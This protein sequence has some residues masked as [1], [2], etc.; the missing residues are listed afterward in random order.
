ML[1]SSMNNSRPFP[2]KKK[3]LSSMEENYN[4]GNISEH[5]NANEFPQTKTTPFT[6][7]ASKHYFNK[8]NFESIINDN[9]RWDQDQWNVPPGTLALSIALTPFFRTDKRFP[10]YCVEDIVEFMDTKLVFGKEYSHNHFNDDSL[11]L[12]LDRIHEAGSST[13]FSMIASQVYVNFPIAFD[14]IFHLDTTSHVCYGDFKICEQD[15]YEGLNVTYGHSKARRSDKKQI[16]SGMIT[17]SLGIPLHTEVLDGN[18]AD[19]AWFPKAICSFREFFGKMCDESIFIAD[20]KLIS[21]NNFKILYGEANPVS[22]IS[23]CPEKFGLRIAEKTVNEAYSLNKWKYIGAC[24]EDEKLKRAT[25][26]EVQSF[27]K[28]VHEKECRVI[29]YRDIDDNEKLA[30]EIKKQKELIEADIKEKFKKPYSCE[31]DAKKDI[32]EFVKKYKNS[33]FNIKFEIQE[34][35][36]KKRPVGR[37]PKNQ[38]KFEIISEF[39]VKLKSLEQNKENVEKRKRSLETFVLIT[40][41]PSKPK[42]DNSKT[43]DDKEILQLYKGQQVVETNFEE[44]KKPS[45]F[46]RIFLNKPERIE[47]LLMLLHVSLLVRVLM[48]IIARRNLEK[49]KEPLRIDFGRKILKNPTAEKLLRLLSFH[50]VITMD[51]KHIVL[52]KNGKVDHLNKL[53]QLLGLSFESG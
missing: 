52:T 37:A 18:T 47:A 44:L 46:Y 34:V 20:C 53:L 7:L 23:R 6:V 35:T 14:N 24:C 16:M 38:E 17:D 21:K 50:S 22:F 42:N 29:V 28:V 41:V 40:N 48:R 33:L 27:N 5:L 30:Y 51:G 31:P 32:E 49:E 9:I 26:Y 45:M 8:L 1:F 43:K 13:L 19:V 36:I 2:N 25:K 12:L 15:D 11:G 4:C 3:K 10:L 39:H